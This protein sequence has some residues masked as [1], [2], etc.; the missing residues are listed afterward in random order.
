LILDKNGLMSFIVHPDYLID[1][2]LHSL[3]KQLLGHLRNLN[4]KTSIWSTLPSEVDR[5]WRARS[6]MHLVANGDRW[7]IEGEGSERAV[8]AY[9]I[10]MDGKLA[11]DLDFG[12]AHIPS[13]PSA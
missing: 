2:R 13:I 7:R 8:L 9:A 6:R 10:N 3:Y 4:A 11:Y 12:A 1:D 5:W